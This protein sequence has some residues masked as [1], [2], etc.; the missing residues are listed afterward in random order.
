MARSMGVAVVW[1]VVGACVVPLAWLAGS[2]CY[3]GVP[4][5][6]GPAPDAAAFEAATAPDGASG[7]DGGVP[8]DA[9][10]EA[11]DAGSCA[12]DGGSPFC[13]ALVP[14]CPAVTIVESTA[15]LPTFTGGSIAAGTY[16]LTSATAYTGGTCTGALIYP[17]LALTY[18]L[19]ASGT[20][21]GAVSIQNG[22]ASYGSTASGTYSASASTLTIDQ[23]C[24]VNGSDTSSFPFTATATQLTYDSTL[25]PGGVIQEA[26]GGFCGELVVVL[27]KR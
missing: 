21:Q 17:A 9:G 7:S 3:G 27:T 13:S 15:S 12:F 2:G 16:V 1:A 26:D 14:P 23:T 24:D 10:S 4:T 19:T 20:F 6:P 25:S 22:T 5:S 18:E 11:G 8:A